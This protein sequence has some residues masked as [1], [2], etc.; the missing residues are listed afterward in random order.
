[1]HEARSIWMGIDPRRG[2]TRVLAMEGAGEILLKA[3]LSTAPSHPRALPALLEAV[4]LWQG[5]PVRAALVVGESA[6]T[7]AEPL[8]RDPFSDFGKNPLY[9]L[10]YVS[11]LRRPR[12][13]DGISGMGSFSDLQQLLLFELAR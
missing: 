4:A 5:L 8:Y 7:T 2:E 6:A 1:M 9:T 3:R 11:S 13:K 10:D 12:V